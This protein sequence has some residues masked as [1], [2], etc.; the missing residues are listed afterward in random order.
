[1]IV[2]PCEKV[3]VPFTLFIY[4]AFKGIHIKDLPTDMTKEAL[5]EEVKK[6]GAVRPNSLQIREYPEVG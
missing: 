1:M 3:L 4:A 6:F 5:L 2:N